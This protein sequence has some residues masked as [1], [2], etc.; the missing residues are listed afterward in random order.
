M[1]KK[2]LI[3]AYQYNSEAAQTVKVAFIKNA[4]LGNECYYRFV[5]DSRNKK[6]FE[7][8]MVKYKEI[9]DE[10]RMLDTIKKSV[11]SKVNKMKDIQVLYK[12]GER[13]SYCE[14]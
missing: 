14:L 11:L 4:S 1:A 10:F 13:S 3:A 12:L 9:I 2:T 8:R 5:Y 6:G 7:T